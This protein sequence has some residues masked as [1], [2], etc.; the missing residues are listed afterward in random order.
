MYKVVIVDDEYIVVEGIKAIIERENIGCEVVGCAYNGQE[1][2]DVIKT[3]QPDIVITDIRMPG[4]T[5]LQMIEE[6]VGQTDVEFVIISGYQEFEY[7]RKAMEF[8]VR[9]YID[10]PITIESVKNALLQVKSVL[11]IKKDYY[12]EAS[13]KLINMITAEE[14]EGGR[15]QLEVTLISL[16]Q[17]VA[18]I[19]EYKKEAY[20]LVCLAMG[21][22]FE[23]RKAK[24]KKQRMPS[25]ENIRNVQNFDEIDV[26]V[27]ELFKSMFEK[28]KILKMGGVH[29]TI[30]QV[31][32][33]LDEHY[34]QDVGLA[35]LAEMAKVNY[36]YLSVLF[37]EEVGM[38]FIKYLTEI[39]L[40]H[41]KS[42]LEEG[43]KVSE[44]A[45]LVGY[46]NYRYFCEIFKKNEGI[47]PNEYKGRVRKK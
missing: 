38:S 16:K 45:S 31:L 28:I 10:K 29:S 13:E 34:S 42:F 6:L 9:S 19:E 5:G 33:Y 4:K 37:K 1:G 20:K 21:I 26:F 30:E 41:A 11:E 8:G 25:Y 46:S 22:F 32:G 2:M 24:D 40:E 12:K 27:T 43:Y 39:R 18:D 14:H 15:K 44:V 23:G 35:E 47:T 3:L 17:Y 7:A 36:V